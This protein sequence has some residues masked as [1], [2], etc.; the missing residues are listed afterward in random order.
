MTRQNR[1]LD[2]G[3]VGQ[4]LDRYGFYGWEVRS[5]VLFGSILTVVYPLG[6]PQARAGETPGLAGKQNFGEMQKSLKFGILDSLLT[7]NPNPNPP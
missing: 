5:G 3:C 7:P 6:V 1:K 2:P 4:G